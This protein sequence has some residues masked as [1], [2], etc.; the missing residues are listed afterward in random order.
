MYLCMN[1]G[2][3]ECRDIRPCVYVVYVYTYRCVC[4]VRYVC[5][6]CRISSLHRSSQT[7]HAFHHQKRNERKKIHVNRKQIQ[8][9]IGMLW[10]T[11]VVSQVPRAVLRMLFCVCQVLN[12]NNEMKQCRC[13]FTS[14]KYTA[15]MRQLKTSKKQEFH[16]IAKE[17]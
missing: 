6:Q 12:I 1:E 15:R 14:P 9:T 11:G 16:P 8:D 13:K 7:K 3:N 17:K 10:G 5:K 2:I 4:P